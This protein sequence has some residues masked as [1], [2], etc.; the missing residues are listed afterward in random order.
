[1]INEY[2][3]QGK[4]LEDEAVHLLFSM[5]R[6]EAKR[7]ILDSLSS[8]ETIICDWYAYSGVAYS[9]AK[10]LDFQWCKNPD[11][12]LPR[13]D[14]VFFIDATTAQLKKREGYGEERYEKVE[15]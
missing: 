9:S 7:D 10:G 13:P 15:F 2:L 14:L 8:G 4:A 6:W 1:M 3:S 11:Q 12:N 5:N